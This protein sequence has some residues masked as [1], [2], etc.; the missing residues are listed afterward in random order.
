MHLC[1]IRSI[2][3]VSVAKFCDDEID[4]FVGCHVAKLLSYL[5]SEQCLDMG[6]RMMARVVSVQ[7]ITWMTQRFFCWFYYYFLLIFFY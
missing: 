3:D 6:V 1:R 7:R 5:G 2:H 4:R